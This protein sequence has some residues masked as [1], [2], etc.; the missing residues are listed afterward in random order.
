VRI[1]ATATE[2]T[3]ARLMDR[4]VGGKFK[5]GR[6]IGC[7]SFGEI[8]LGERTD[9]ALPRSPIASFLLSLPLP[10]RLVSAWVYCQSV[11]T[12]VPDL[13][14]AVT[15]PA[16]HVD[17]YEIV[18]V[19]IVSALGFSRLLLLTPLPLAEFFRGLLL[20]LRVSGRGYGLSGFMCSNVPSSTYQSCFHQRMHISLFLERE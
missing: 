2:N 4:I 10:A 5:L 12:T 6:K 17:T 16:T 9:S 11:I 8:Y 20:F 19:K 7:G 14:F 13:L 3:G 1:A 15:V 18:A